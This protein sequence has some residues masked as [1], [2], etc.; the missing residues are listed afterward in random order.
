MPGISQIFRFFT[1]KAD[2]ARLGGH[3]IVEST[4]FPA[5]HDREIR[6]RRFDTL[7][8]ILYDL[9]TPALKVKNR[10]ICDIR[11]FDINFFLIV[12]VRVI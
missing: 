8:L 5:I 6:A 1:L 4:D 11:G 2:C 9:T 3:R 12:R 10:E 7:Y